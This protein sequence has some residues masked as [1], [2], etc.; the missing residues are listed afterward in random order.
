MKGKFLK[1]VFMS[2]AVA[3]AGAG[4]WKA[5]EVYASGN[6]S[7]MLLAENVE[8]LSDG[9]EAN[10]K[11]QYSG[12]LVNK[13]IEITECSS[14]HADLSFQGH[15][16]VCIGGLL[17]YETKRYVPGHYY[18]CFGGARQTRSECYAVI[19]KCQHH[20]KGIECNKLPKWSCSGLF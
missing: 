3:V 11:Y 14:C 10:G 4:C 2:A 13:A 20:A 19:V 7:E 18:D 8:A 6:E 15:I 16:G 17:G 9:D 1:S 5:Y 12:R